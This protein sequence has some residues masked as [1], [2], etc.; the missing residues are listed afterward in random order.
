MAERTDIP[1]ELIPFLDA[2]AEL[3]AEDY[4]RHKLIDTVRSPQRPDIVRGRISRGWPETDDV[5]D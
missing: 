2:L 1:K 5:S 4:E 3:L